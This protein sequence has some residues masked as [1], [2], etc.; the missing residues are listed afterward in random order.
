MRTQKIDW[1]RCKRVAVIPFFFVTQWGIAQEN[2]MDE[3]V[4]TATRSEKPL[5]TIPNTITVI[6]RKALDQQISI[7]NDL[8]TILGNLIPSYSPSRQ[9]L[10][11][12]GE[13]LRGRKPLYLI[14]GVPQ[15]NPL[16]NSERDGHTIDPLMLERVEV[17]HGANAIHGLGASGGIINLITKKPGEALQQ[18]VRIESSAQEEDLGEGLS[19]GAAYSLSGQFDAFDLLASVSYRSTGIGYDADGEVIGFDNTQ[20]DTMDS[21][22]LNAFFKAGYD[23]DDQRLELTVNHYDIAGNNDWV[24]VPGDL[25]AGIPTTA[26]KGP[27][28]GDTPGN[29]VTTLSL[30]YANDEFLGHSLRVHA[31][32]QDF[33]GTFG[34]GTFGTFQDPAFGADVYDQSQN[35]SEKQGLKI[36]LV[37]DRIGGAPVNL[38]Y[39]IDFFRD[40]TWQ[41]LIHTGRNWVPDT[42]YNNYAPYLQAE[43]T[44]VDKLTVT[45]GLRHEQSELEVDDFTTLFSNNGGQAV[46]GGNP[47]FSETLYNTGATFRVTEAWRVFGNYSEGFS[48]PDVGRVLRG[49]SIPNQSVESFLDLEPILTENAELG[50]E[51]SGEKVS[52][53]LS[54]YESDSDFGQRLQAD[55]DGIFSVKRE[56]TEIDGIEFR[57]QWFATKADVLALRYAKTDGESD[58]NGDGNVDSDL[59]GRNIAPDRIN[60]SWDRNWSD[61][62]ATRVQVNHLLDRNFKNSAGVTTNEFDGYTTL[63]LNAE[64]RALNGTFSLSVQNLTNEDYFTYYSQSGGGND[65]R[66]FKGLG[67]GFSVSYHRQF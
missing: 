33:A 38:V 8:S 28:P 6:D 50:I 63:D 42:E 23:W 60:L 53:Q 35:N 24:A 37:K 44:G 16:R 14:D 1:H 30:N 32:S 65:G 7:N 2:G 58:T 10:T 56:K 40:T 59:D 31:F 21:D 47:D 5:S 46:T 64:L 26:E 36:T 51:Y 52:A 49:I 4:V 29:E 39:G 27:V 45:A 25:D 66:N 18:S 15:S 57:T 34:G 12:S 3:I 43:F 13:R 41:E 61:R 54:Y 17:I 9:K 11:N 62:L 19:Y 20:G 67:R 55:A 22:A 48:M